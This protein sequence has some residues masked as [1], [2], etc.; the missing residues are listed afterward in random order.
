MATKGEDACQFWQA[1]LVVEVIVVGHWYTGKDFPTCRARESSFSCEYL[2]QPR[3]GSPMYAE[4]LQPCTFSLA[5][6]Y[7]IVNSTL[8]ISHEKP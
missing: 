3:I 6:S 2:S 5:V 8:Y 1:S 4:T 7:S